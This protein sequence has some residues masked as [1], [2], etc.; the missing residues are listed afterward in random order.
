MKSREFFNEDKTPENPSYQEMR[1]R[2]AKE[3]ITGEEKDLKLETWLKQIDFDVLQDMFTERI[4][5]TGISSEETNVLRSDR[6]SHLYQRGVSAYIPHTNKILINQKLIKEYAARYNIDSY[7]IFLWTLVH[8]ETHAVSKTRC[9]NLLGERDLPAQIQS[10]YSS[11][12][13]EP[14][15]SGIYKSLGRV[16]ELFNEGVTEKQARELSREY[17]H[18]TGYSDT[19]NGARYEQ[20]LKESYQP[21]N[22]AIQVLEAFIRRLAA[23]EGIEEEAAW[24]AI[25]RG[26]FE[27]E[28]LL[29]REMS[30]WLNKSMP[31]DFMD[32]ILMADD[33][34]M[35]VLLRELEETPLKKAA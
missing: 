21:Y 14:D 18:R 28:D 6:I 8:E 25:K 22:R 26:Y 24:D 9:W 12:V 34:D 31:P 4:R 19:K 5:K 30:E 13:L 35:I 15:A 32:K 16:F 29:G 7:L 27:G 33:E 10:G 23:I 11:S 1:E 2:I 20:F 3:E 17:L